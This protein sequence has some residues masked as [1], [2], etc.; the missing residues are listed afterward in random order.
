MGDETSQSNASCTLVLKLRVLYFSGVAEDSFY[1]H[2]LNGLHR[3]STYSELQKHWV[4]LTTP[5]T[6]F[7]AISRM[8]TVRSQPEPMIEH[9]VKGHSR[10]CDCRWKQF[11]FVTGSLPFPN[12]I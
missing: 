6:G 7:I 11:T 3:R 4:T 12:L 2:V 8:G 1:I 5:D 10:A 9:L